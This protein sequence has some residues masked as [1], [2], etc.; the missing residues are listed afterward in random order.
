MAVV[1][2]GGTLPQ[3]QAHVCGACVGTWFDSALWRMPGVVCFG[4]E[5]VGHVIHDHKHARVRN[6]SVEVVIEIKFFV[7]FR[8]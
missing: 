4:F 7:D 5:L 6:V 2:R 8:A 1:T 3:G